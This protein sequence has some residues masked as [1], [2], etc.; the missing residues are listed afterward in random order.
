[1]T[2]AQIAANARKPYADKIMEISKSHKQLL[3]AL[4]AI[5]KHWRDND[6]A[7]YASDLATNALDTIHK[8]NSI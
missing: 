5:V 8:A 2:H 7:M 1:M 3:D 4:E 6:P